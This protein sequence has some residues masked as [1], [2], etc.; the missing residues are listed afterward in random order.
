MGREF[1]QVDPQL[2]Y[3]GEALDCGAVYPET[4]RILLERIGRPLAVCDGQGRGVKENAG[5][6]VRNCS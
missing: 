2:A 4:L 3:R 1:L 5:F 6:G